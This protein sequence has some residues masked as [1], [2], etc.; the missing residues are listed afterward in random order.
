MKAKRLFLVLALVLALVLP[1]WSANKTVTVKP[2]GGTYTTLAAAIAG[3]LIANADL[4]AMAGILNIEIGGTW[5]SA[6]TTAVVINGFTT[7]AAYYPN[8]YTDAA[9]RA[10]MPWSTSKYNLS[11]ANAS[12]LLLIDD[13]IRVDGLQISVTSS[14]ASDQSGI[15]VYGQTSGANDIRISGCLIKGHANAT[16][17]NFG[18]DVEDSDTVLSIWD[19]IV[20]GTSTHASSKGINVNAASTV[21]LYNVT[22]IGGTIGVGRN[23]GTVTAKNCY[24][25]GTSTNDYNGTISMTTCASEDDT[26]SAGLQTI[27]VDTDTFV[28]VTATTEDYHLAIDGLSPLQNVG[29]DTSGDAAPL[30]FTTDMDGESFADD[31]DIGAFANVPTTTTLK[32]NLA[33]IWSMI[34]AAFSF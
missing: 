22:V 7:S 15:A 11:T 12:A 26:G 34:C 5:S 17:Y 1:G 23:A 20:Y 4:T 29:T 8:I 27:A 14:N 10:S 24:A 16:Y 21:S 6:D 25:G 3:E 28:N 30:N 13:H 32:P 31:W 33:I 19:C 9:N 2:S 18:I